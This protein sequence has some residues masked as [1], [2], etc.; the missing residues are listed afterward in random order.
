[1][2]A[3]LTETGS[4][5]CPRGVGGPSGAGGRPSWGHPASLAQRPQP[6]APGGPPP[7]RPL[8]FCSL[9]GFCRIRA[10]RSTLAPAQTSLV[11]ALSASG[12]PALPQVDIQARGAGTVPWQLYT[13]LHLPRGS[14][15]VVPGP[16]TGPGVGDLW[17]SWVCGRGL[18]KKVSGR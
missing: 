13:H 10:L 7:A 15:L 9:E 11:L 12:D 2:D 1:M 14:S 18:I 3:A 8:L 5:P 17:A 16:Q 6:L 4:G